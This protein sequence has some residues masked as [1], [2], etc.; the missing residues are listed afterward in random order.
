MGFK[1]MKILLTGAS[2][3][4]GRK[5][6]TA[7]APRYSD[8]RI[9]ARNEKAKQYLENQVHA[10]IILTEDLFLETEEWFRKQCQNVDAVIHMAWYTDPELYQ[11]S[12][13]NLDCLTGSLR[14]AKA[15][16]DVGV[17]R[18]IGIGTCFEYEMS[19]D[20]LDTNSPLNPMNCYGGAKASLY[21]TL[22][23]FFKNKKSD[24]TWC[25]LFHLYGEG[26]DK[27]RLSAHIRSNLEAGNKVEL[28]DG[29]QILDFMDV[30]EAGRKI[31]DTLAD[32]SLKVV[33]IC[34]G[35]PVTVRQF[36]ET[37]A[38]EY[39]RRDLLSFGAIESIG[40]A[41]LRIVGVPNTSE[42]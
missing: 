22:N 42:E 20:N 28:T 35:K 30:A 13:K 16:A 18:F 12:D 39:E 21:L 17:K 5:V 14:F 1:N 34:T 38:D 37:I 15:A 11:H 7:L 2:G 19:D 4:V 9:I 8:F 41:P 10:D 33:N 27:R 6:L 36:A 3:F 25:R 24:F 26:E 32:R 40:N 29:T 23:Q 31:A